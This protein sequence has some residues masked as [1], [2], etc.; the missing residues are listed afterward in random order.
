MVLSSCNTLRVDICSM[1]HDSGL[2]QAGAPGHSQYRKKTAFPQLAWPRSRGR[3]SLEHRGQQRK[4]SRYTSLA[5]WK[6]LPPIDPSCPSPLTQNFP[7]EVA[8][9]LK[10]GRL[11]TLKPQ[12]WWGWGVGR[13]S[14]APGTKYNLERTKWIC[15][16]FPWNN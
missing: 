1:W 3:L 12:P 11:K 14:S 9:S 5:V 13:G 4:G 6:L 16:L 7:K 2:F 15:G 8:F 10:Q